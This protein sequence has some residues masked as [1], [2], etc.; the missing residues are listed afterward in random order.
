MAAGYGAGWHAH[1]D[2]LVAV[3]GGTEIPEWDVVFSAVL[4]HY[5]DAT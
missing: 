3:I 1:G 5:S 2:Q 4:P